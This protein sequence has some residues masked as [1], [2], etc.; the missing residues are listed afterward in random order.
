MKLKQY[1]SNSHH[2]KNKNVHLQLNNSRHALKYLYI[3]QIKWYD[4]H[5]N[6]ANINFNLYSTPEILSL[7]GRTVNSDKR[8]KKGGI[9]Y[10]YKIIV[11]FVDFTVK[12]K[13]N[14]TSTNCDN[15]SAS[16]FDISI[17]EWI[18]V[19]YQLI[20]NPIAFLLYN[21]WKTFSTFLLLLS[22]FYRYGNYWALSN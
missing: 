17:R 6:R 2:G 19:N 13:H 7:R 11:C 14:R 5:G 16:H 9:V 10:D 21:F 8:L 20:C 15:H 3:C 12:P 22:F 1:N 18:Q 4:I